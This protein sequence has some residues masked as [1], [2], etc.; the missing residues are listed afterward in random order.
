MTTSLHP[1]RKPPAT[2]RRV[3]TRALHARLRRRREHVRPGTTRVIRVIAATLALCGTV[4][5]IDLALRQS[6][7][8][9]R[10]DWLPEPVA[11]WADAHGRF[12]NFPAFFLLALPFLSFARRSSGRALVTAALAI[13]ATLLELA[14][15]F[16]PQRWVEWQDIA[17]S[18]AGLA[19]AWM[20]F[21]GAH[22]LQS[23]RRHVRVSAHV[24]RRVRRTSARGVS[25]ASS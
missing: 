8:L 18:C 12:R 19:C 21:E 22:A 24:H 14:Q 11:R 3:S 23:W 6:G 13:F 5:A 1:R 2:S 4:A 20:I 25:A 16:R 15:Y 10:V 7:Y 17:W 9:Q